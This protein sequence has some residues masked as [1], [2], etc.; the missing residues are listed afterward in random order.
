MIFKRKSHRDCV[1]SIEKAAF[2]DKMIFFVKKVVELFGGLK[3][4]PYLCNVKIKE[5]LA[6]DK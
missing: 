6:D 3:K 1:K 4:T 5:R 2:F